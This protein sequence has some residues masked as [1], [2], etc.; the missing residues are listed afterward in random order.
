MAHEDDRRFQVRPL[1][2]RVN[3]LDV[4]LQGSATTR[5]NVAATDAGTIERAEPH[6]SE[7]MT[8]DGPGLRRDSKAAVGQHNGP[9]PLHAIQ[10]RTCGATLTAAAK[11]S[12]VCFAALLE[13]TQRERVGIRRRRGPSSIEA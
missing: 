11:R 13:S 12:G 5:A 2:E 8:D 1:D 3:V 6:M 10:R 7:V 9:S 4:A